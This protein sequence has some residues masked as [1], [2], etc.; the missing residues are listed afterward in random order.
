M[1]S[2]TTELAFVRLVIPFIAGILLFSAVSRL[3]WLIPMGTIG[4]IM[5]STLFYLNSHYASFN[6]RRYKTYIAF[7]FYFLPI[8]LGGSLC[9]LKKENLNKN[10][11]SN[12]RGEYLQVIVNEEPQLKNNIIRFNAVV[13]NS[14]YKGKF[15]PVIGHL[16]VS[17]NTKNLHQTIEYG[18]QY[19]LPANF[20]VIP[21]P[22]NPAEF[23]V[24]TWYGHQ[25]IYHQ[26]FVQPE[27][28][29][30]QKSGLGN[31]IISWALKIRK[32][33]VDLFRK[34]L[35][36][37]EAYAVATTLLLGYRADLSEETLMAYSK[38]GTI[39]ALSVSGMHVGL[40]YLVINFL[41]GFLDKTNHGRIIKLLLTIAL[42]WFYALVAGLAPSV[43]RSAIM[44]SVF[45][46][47]NT[48][49]RSKNSYNLLC[50]S[51]FSILVFNPLLI[52][53]LGFQLSYLSVLGLIYFQPYINAWFHFKFAFANKLWGFIALS[54]AAQLSTFPLAAYY[55]H[56]FP[57]YFLISNLFILLPVTV[58]MYLGL[59]IILCRMYFLAPILEW[60]INFCNQGLK[61]I[62][63]LPS[64]SLSEIWFDQMELLLLSFGL[65]CICIACANFNKLLLLIGFSCFCL[66]V[67][68]LAY[69]NYL[70][71]RQRSVLFFSLRKSSA[72]AFIQKDSAWV[73]S[74]LSK[75]SKDIK[76]FVLPA[77]GKSGV[78]SIT[79][80]K[81]HQAINTRIFQSGEHQIHFRG[82]NLLLIDTCFN[83][84]R[85][86]KPVTFNAIN[87][88]GPSRLQLDLIL[89]K[90]K[91]DKLFID[92]S[93][94]AY[95]V[96]YYENVAKNFN[97]TTYDL[98]IKKAYLINLNE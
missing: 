69:D 74:P 66:L 52:Y 96:K 34:L 65:L 87:L 13:I 86:T 56:Q 22:H 43:L 68:S 58:I 30:H 9:L 81:P 38:T 54:L 91:A 85:L 59:L 29:L 4:V 57:T 37:D 26:I 63:N 39:H 17:V 33:Q 53:D 8:L 31:P 20:L 67:L 36:Q 32:Q 89:N 2:K 55:F 60:L 97:L 79:Y 23:D 82:F 83:H 51:A 14:F 95:Q 90:T 40:I 45:I 3:S 27:Q 88:S 50:F 24:K 28:L 21:E 11:F 15:T 44:L 48:F 42:I 47:G 71:Q 78:K 6:S 49:K 5:L 77:L 93:N 73:F 84:K 1:Q 25:N 94:A 46:I 61:W 62:S 35:V 16:I 7:C 72:I 92:G 98:K 76:Y 64:A 80:L 41:L 10:H 18:N 70:V 19:I 12:I 75:E